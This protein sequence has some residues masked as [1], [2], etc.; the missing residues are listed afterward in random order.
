MIKIEKY[1]EYILNL[2]FLRREDY[3]YQNVIFFI[4]YQILFYTYIS[5]L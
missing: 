4:V 2:K 5:L 3:N 1:Y